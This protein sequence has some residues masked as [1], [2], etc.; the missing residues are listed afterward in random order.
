[1]IIVALGERPYRARE[2]RHWCDDA[3]TEQYDCRYERGGKKQRRKRENK[4]TGSFETV[5][6]FT[7]KTVEF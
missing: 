1:M 3:V 4:I 7:Q 6:A 5:D 2:Q